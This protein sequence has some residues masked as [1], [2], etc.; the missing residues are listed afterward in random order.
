MSAPRLGFRALMLLAL[1]LAAC[2]PSA[3][4]LRLYGRVDAALEIADAMQRKLVAHREAEGRWPSRNEWQDFHYTSPTLDVP[5][6]LQA[7][8]DGR[9]VV[10]FGGGMRSTRLSGSQLELVPSG[11]GQVWHCSN[12]DVPVDLLPPRCR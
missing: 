1:P 3:E 5:F 11:G 10:S 7:H 6:V 2:G 9:I 4:D 8:D 12:R